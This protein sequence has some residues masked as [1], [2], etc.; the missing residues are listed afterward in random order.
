ML[1]NQLIIH[2]HL[3]L[4]TPAIIGTQLYMLSIKFVKHYAR[5]TQKNYYLCCVKLATATSDMN[6]MFV[7]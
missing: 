1:Y 3:H 6:Q 7:I 4:V 2:F 5:Y